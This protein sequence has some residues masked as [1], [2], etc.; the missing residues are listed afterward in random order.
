MF[1]SYSYKSVLQFQYQIIT[2]SMPLGIHKSH[3]V[4]NAVTVIIS[5]G[6]KGI[7]R[8]SLPPLNNSE[9]PVPLELCPAFYSP[10]SM[11]V[12]VPDSMVYPCTT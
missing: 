3:L 6:S 10:I 12:S 2:M 5:S 11:Q 8:M 7:A 9:E 4:N 1:I